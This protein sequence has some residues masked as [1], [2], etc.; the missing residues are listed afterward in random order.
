MTL[1]ISS[2]IFFSEPMQKISKTWVMYLFCG[3]IAW[4]ALPLGSNR[5][6][7]VNILQI[8]IGL[9]FLLTL[10]A[11]YQQHTARLLQ[12][13]APLLLFAVF[14]S[15]ALIQLIPMPI[16]LVSQLSPN[17]A[18]PYLLQQEHWITLSTES[19]MSRSA[20]NKTWMFFCVFVIAL[21]VFT[22]A[23]NIELML[24]VIVGIG[25]FQG[26]YGAYEV[27]LQYDASLMFNIP[28]K[29]RASGTFVYHNHFA[30]YLVLCLSAGMGLIVMRTQNN[31]LTS[32]RTFLLHAFAGLVSKKILI[33]LA[34]VI[35]VIALVMSRSRMGNISFFL[36]MT[37]VGA[38]AFITMRNRS[39]GLS[40]LLLSIF[41]IDLFLLS[42]W[43]GLDKI[44]ARLE[45]TS[46]L[47][48][49]RDEVLRDALPIVYDFPLFGSG[50][51]TFYSIFPQYQATKVHGFYDHLHN[52]FVQFTIEYGF[53][54][55]MCLGLLVL[56]A[57]IN[58]FTVMRERHNALCKGASFACLLAISATLMHM[59]V[60]FP[61]QSPA[62]AMLFVMYLAMAFSLAA[63]PRNR[64]KKRLHSEPEAHTIS[65]II[66][67]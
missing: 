20:F 28:Y 25:A 31:R 30:N 54:G 21:N 18:A 4:S 5:P 33:R 58:A 8:F 6:W 7:A 1:P 24:W 45:N 49:T 22:R 12:F 29:D 42:A 26:L 65:E 2:K 60:D 39:V 56:L 3:I 17:S 13:K 53:L 14:I 16:G 50:G 44:K 46:L 52:D 38:L 40:I 51:N 34:L 55:V 9:T 43:F 35:M 67:E 64:V 23:K 48:E 32:L 15:I 62:N 66:T 41:F 27:L 19:S 11:Y 10:F 59:T 63:L 37:L 61:L 57:I 47:N 36:S